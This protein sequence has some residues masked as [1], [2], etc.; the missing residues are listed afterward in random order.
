VVVNSGNANACTGARGAR[1]AGRTAAL[2][3]AAL[4]APER[5][6]AVASTGVIGRM[7]PMERIERAVP[8]LVGE[9]APDR[10]DA[11]SRA[12]LTTDRFAKVA[13]IRGQVGGARVT[14]TGVAKGAGMIAP[15]MATMLAFVLTDAA[16]TP[17]LLR[18]IVRA[19]ADRTFN[20]VTVDGDTSTNDSLFLLASG[21]AGN[22]PVEADGRDARRLRTL[23]EAVLGALA[24][25]LVADGEGATKVVRVQVTGAAGPVEAAAVARRIAESPLVKTALH[26]ADPNFGRILCAAGNAG[27]PLAPS[28]LTLHVGAVPVV[29][30]GVA[31]PG[32]R[33]PM[34]AV[35][36]AARYTMRLDLGRGRGAAE[37]RTCDL[38]TAYVRLNAAY[39]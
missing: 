34:R 6:V 25:L 33:S 15:D 20:A 2:V 16:A 9:L 4:G 39:S 3:A 14:V 30:R 10:L 7:L 37:V 36:Q 21:S 23:V 12:I 8:H 22:A 38:G 26:G 29:R 19:V 32:H 28:R 24:E 11:F 35:M 31:V 13:T 27:V 18:R 17:P 5:A 1:D